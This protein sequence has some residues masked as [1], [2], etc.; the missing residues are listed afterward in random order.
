MII[1]M[2][3]HNA[4]IKLRPVPSSHTK[5]LRQLDIILAHILKIMQKCLIINN[6]KFCGTNHQMIL[7]HVPGDFYPKGPFRMRKFSEIL[8][9]R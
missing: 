6:C 5:L 3:N 4:Y 2:A 7:L 1:F 9:L 8:D